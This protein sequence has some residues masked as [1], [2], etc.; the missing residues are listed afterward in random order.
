MAGAPAASKHRGVLRWTK[1]EV[2]MDLKGAQ[3]GCCGS[4]QKAPR[5]RDSEEAVSMCVRLLRRASSR[6]PRAQYR[7]WSRSLCRVPRP[8]T[9]KPETLAKAGLR[10]QGVVCKRLGAKK[11]C[12]LPI[13]AT[14]LV[15]GL[16][17]RKS[18]RQ[19]LGPGTRRDRKTCT[20]WRMRRSVCALAELGDLSL[21]ALGSSRCT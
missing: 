17:F 7:P 13:L 15:L 1:A 16:V 20:A 14:E 8:R 6:R 12:G 3:C 18:L 11:E 10:I 2:K 19:T 4:S 9:E 21:G 5:M